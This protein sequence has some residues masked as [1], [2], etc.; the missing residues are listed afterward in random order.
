MARASRPPLD[1]GEQL[2]K[3]AFDTVDHGALVLPEAFGERWGVLLVY[4]AHW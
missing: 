3:L 1:N 2:P 4:R